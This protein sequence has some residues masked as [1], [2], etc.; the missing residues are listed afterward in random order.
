MASQTPAVE[1]A[2]PRTSRRQKPPHPRLSMKLQV[3]L[4]GSAPF[5]RT[6]DVLLPR[7]GGVYIIHDLRGALYVGR[8]GDLL[9]RFQEHETLPPN[10]LIGMARRSAVGPLHFSWITLPDARRPPSMRRP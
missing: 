1:L 3:R 10:R 6:S 7:S 8:T 4:D 2:P 9:R 5:R